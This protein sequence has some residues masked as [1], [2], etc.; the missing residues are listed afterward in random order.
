M[1][2]GS[3]TAL[4]DEPAF[5]PAPLT[6]PGLAKRPPRGVIGCVHGTRRIHF[7]GERTAL[8]PEHV[9]GGIDFAGWRFASLPDFIKLA[10]G[11]NWCFSTGPVVN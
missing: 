9:V 3:G 11:E 4:L 2:A 6:D 7:V 1:V 5:S 8:A 10:A